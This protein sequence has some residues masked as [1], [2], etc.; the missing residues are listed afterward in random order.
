MKMKKLGR[1]DV[2]VSEI[3]LG[4][5]TWGKQNSEAEAHAQLDRAMAAGINFVDTAELYA[6]P[7]TAETLADRG[8]AQGV[9]GSA[10]A[11]YVH[12]GWLR[13]DLD[14]RVHAF[15]EPREE[16]GTMRMTW[17]EAQR[18]RTVAP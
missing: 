8:L 10:R 12:P 14:V 6:V 7:A 18:I 15:G 4:T 11:Q 5:M 1:T 13:R 9:Y 16:D 2:M 3:C 17:T